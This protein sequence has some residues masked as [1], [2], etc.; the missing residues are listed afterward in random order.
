MFEK[1]T[2]QK[3]LEQLKK[4]GFKVKKNQIEL[5]KPLQEIGEFPIKIKFEHNLEAEIKVIIT[6][7]K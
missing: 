6:E 2:V 5:E 4:L 1:I 3:V 7:E